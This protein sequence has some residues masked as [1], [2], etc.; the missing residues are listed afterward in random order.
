MD[1]PVTTQRFEDFIKAHQRE[2]ELEQ[3]ALGE[4]RTN[5]DQ[6]LRG[7]NEIREQ[8]NKERGQYVDRDVFD[9][10]LGIFDERFNKLEKSVTQIQSANA[11]WLIAIGVF[12]TLVQIVLRFVPIG[13]P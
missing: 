3:L 13:K 10:K 8:I 12:F 5:I 7:M 11:T 2:H 6:R 9:A 1:T 4:A